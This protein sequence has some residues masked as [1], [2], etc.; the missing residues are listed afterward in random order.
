MF[1]Y[2]FVVQLFSRVRLLVSPWTVAPQASLSFTISQSLLKLMA[3]ISDALQ[4]SCPLSS[5]SL[6]AFNLS[7]DQGVF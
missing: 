5:P 7:K 1:S 4:P 2:T 3:L 6:P